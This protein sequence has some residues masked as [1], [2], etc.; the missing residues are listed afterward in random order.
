MSNLNKVL[1]MGRLGKDP[2]VRYTADGT[3]VASFTMATS[4]SYKDRSGNKQERTEWHNIVVW[5]KLAEI[6]GEYLKK[7]RLVYI[8]G[9]IQ[10]REYEGK[11]GIKRRV[12][13]IVASDMKMMPSGQGQGQNQSYPQEERRGFGSSSKPSYEDDFVPEDDVPM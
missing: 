5:R 6:A 2:E 13:E 11:D 12:Y 9:R 3:A 4:E 1:L 7:G 8:E 10:S